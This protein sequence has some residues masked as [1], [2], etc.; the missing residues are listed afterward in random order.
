MTAKAFQQYMEMY[1]REHPYDINFIQ[2]GLRQV[3]GGREDAPM[4]HASNMLPA[5]DS[6]LVMPH[7]FIANGRSKQH[8][9]DYFELAYLSRGH[10][11]QTIGELSCDLSE[12]DLC[13]LNPYI[14]HNVDVSSPTDL[15]F[16]IMIKPS[17]FQ[18]AFLQRVAGDDF[19]ST[20]FV[21]A[22][23]T[24]SRQKSFLYF[25]RKDN[26]QV[27]AFVQSLIIEYF[28]KKTAYQK[29]VE[30]YLA[31]LFTELVRNWQNDIDQENY[32]LMGNHPLSSILAYINQ[33]KEDVTLASVAEHF[34]YHPKYLSTLIKKYTDKS[35]SQI[36]QE[37]K[38]AEICYY[39]K[40]T[41]MSI[42]ELS[43]M[44]GYYDRSYFNRMFK[45]TFHMSPGQYREQLGG[46]L[47]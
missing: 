29:A 1:F 40:N 30:N 8:S 44:M 4:L 17:L 12:G 10:C 46:S 31:L 39:L 11:T 35:F 20:F 22:I 5:K 2:D 14:T 43:K 24:A 16:N 47:P 13:L 27:T 19:I 9:H 6:I 34:H 7:P 15:L 45:K 41:D 25:P 3:F 26:T 32:A 36:V 42:D 21:N 18:N 28:E 33:H 23:F 37:A 38:L